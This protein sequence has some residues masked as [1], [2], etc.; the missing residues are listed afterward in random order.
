MREAATVGS[1]AISV[2]DD[3]PGFSAEH[4][5]GPITGF[6]STKADG[7]G[8]GLYTAE[9]LVRASGGS[10]ARENGPEGGARV[11]AVLRAVPGR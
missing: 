4:L 6:Q 2:C 7:T 1:V 9:R 10:V 11:T 3:G 5:A 8:L